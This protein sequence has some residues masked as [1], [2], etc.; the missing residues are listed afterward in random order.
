MEKTAKTS[1]GIFKDARA[2]ALRATELA[3]RVAGVL[4]IIQARDRLRVI[5][6]PELMRDGIE[7]VVYSVETWRAV[8]GDRHEAEVRNDAFRLLEWLFNQPGFRASEISILRIGPKPTRSQSRRDTA[9][10]ILQQAGLVVHEMR[11]K[12][13]RAN[14]K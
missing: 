2:F 6:E 8:Q 5:I 11:T 1:D 9:L 3:F 7:L 13:W 4:V 12:T 10:S 14:I